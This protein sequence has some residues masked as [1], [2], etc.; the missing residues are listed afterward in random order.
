MPRASRHRRCR[1]QETNKNSSKAAR[2]KDLLASPSDRPQ[3]LAE[4]PSRQTEGAGHAHVW[5]AQAVARP[6]LWHCRSSPSP[7]LVYREER[8]TCCVCQPPFQLGSPREQPPVT[9][10]HGGPA[11]TPPAMADPQRPLPA[12]TWRST[13]T[14]PRRTTSWSCARGRPTASSRSART[15]GSRA[16]PCDLGS[17]G[18]FL[19]IT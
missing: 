2:P 4:P 12:G 1:E 18:C 13:P 9:G 14:S 5:E 10:W 8:V 7:S 16:R 17:P 15:A 6:W 3:G 19:G 11:R